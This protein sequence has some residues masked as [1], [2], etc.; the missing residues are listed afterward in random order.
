MLMVRYL[1]PKP[2]P[3]GRLRV[4]LKGRKRTMPGGHLVIGLLP[5]I[6]AGTPTAS[7]SGGMSFVTTAP[8]PVAAPAPTVTG[9]TSMVSQPMKASSPM[10][11][12]C[13]SLP[14]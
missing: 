10:M 1:Y 11:V 7:L 12:R 5:V 13:L 8:A 3:P 9:A 14:S 6:L 4:P 2:S